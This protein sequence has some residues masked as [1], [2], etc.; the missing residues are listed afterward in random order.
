MK[1]S[2][3]AEEV[4]DGSFRII[5][6]ETDPVLI[7]LPAGVDPEQKRAMLRLA[8]KERARYLE[9]EEHKRL[10]RS[11]EAIDAWAAWRK[12]STKENENVNPPRLAE[13]AFAWFA[14]RKT[15]DCQLGDLQELYVKNVERYGSNRA[16]WLYWL[17]VFPAIT[18]AA[19]R[20]LK[21]VGFVAFV[22]DYVR[23]KL[24]L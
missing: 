16:R 24:G 18:G 19:W 13:A 11:I 12:R 3:K 23:T 17:E 2:G 4:G 8:I 5:V 9:R 22:V 7:W 14:P 6:G 20:L 1:R 15:A 21:R 10:F